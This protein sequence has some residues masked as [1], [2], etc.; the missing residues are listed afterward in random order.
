MSFDPKQFRGYVDSVLHYMDPEI[1]YSINARELLVFTAAAESELGRYL[2]QIPHGPAR[3]VFQMEEETEDD[4]HRNYLMHRPKLSELVAALRTG[5]RD[6]DMVD[7]LPYQVAM[8]RIHYRRVPDPLPDYRDPYA[9]G[10]YWKRYWNTYLGK[11]RIVDAVGKYLRLAGRIKRE[12][13]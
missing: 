8:A 4:I 13:K 1:P 2:W 3:G 6:N 10:A 9:L 11:G 7:S 12:V 5:L